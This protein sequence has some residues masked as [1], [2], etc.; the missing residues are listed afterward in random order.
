MKLFL[1]PRPSFALNYVALHDRYSMYRFAQAA[2]GCGKFKW[3]LIH[4]VYRPVA[5]S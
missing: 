2:S 5:L 3:Y 1:P 4:G